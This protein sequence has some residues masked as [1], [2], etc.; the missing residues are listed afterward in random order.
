M[1]TYKC[2]K[3]VKAARILEVYE[4]TLV[5]GEGEEF[6]LTDLLKTK[7]SKMAK[8]AGLEIDQ[9]YV[10]QYEDGYVSWSPV[11]VFEKGYIELEEPS[12]EEMIYRNIEAYLR[13]AIIDLA[14]LPDSDLDV[15]NCLVNAISNMKYAV[16][17]QKE[18]RQES[19]RKLMGVMGGATKCGL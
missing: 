6:L 13:A 9:G 11:D 1:K 2:H 5:F 12:H 18:R 10:V 7:F 3:I 19:Q 8:E 4:N 16:Q 14:D 15:I 17:M